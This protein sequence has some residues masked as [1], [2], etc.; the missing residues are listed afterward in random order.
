MELPEELINGL[1]HRIPWR[2]FPIAILDGRQSLTNWQRAEC[3]CAHRV[4]LCT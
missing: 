2:K 3:A 4:P 1:L